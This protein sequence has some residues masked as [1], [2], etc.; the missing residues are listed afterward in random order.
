MICRRCRTA[1]PDLSVYCSGCGR[2]LTQ[3]RGSA[4]PG[5]RPLLFGALGAAVL[6]GLYFLY[7]VVAPGIKPGPTRSTETAGGPAGQPAQT[8]Y[9]S[10][11]LVLGYAAVRGA[12]GREVARITAAVFEDGWVALPTAALLGGEE[13]TFQAGRVGAVPISTGRWEPGEPVALWQVKAG[14]APANPRLAAWNQSLPLEWQPLPPAG[15][16]LRFEVG[17]NRRTGAFIG[18]ARPPEVKAPGVFVQEGAVVGWTFGEPF[19]QAYLW[20]GPAG[21]E[22]TPSIRADQ[23]FSSVSSNSRE[24][25]FLRQLDAGTGETSLVRL[26]ALARGFRLPSLLA[27]EDI[28]PSL[29]SSAVVARMD[30]LIAELIQNG[31][32][33]EVVRVL[34]DQ[35]LREAADP[36]LV[37]GAVLALAKDQD[38]N[39]AIRRLE[40][41]EKD[42]FAARGPAPPEL[43]QFKSRLYKDWL[44]KIVEKGDYYNGLT[45]YEEAQRA[46][47]EDLEIRL[48]GVEAAIAEKSLDRARELLEARDYPPALKE[49]AARLGTQVDSRREDA[50]AVTIRFNPGVEHIPVDAVI[51]GFHLHKFI[52]DTGASMVTIPASAL[53]VLRI[54]VDDST[55][56]KAV[57]TAGG[58]VFA[59]EIT[60]DSISLEKCTVYNVKALVLDIPG[61]EDYGLLGLSFLNGFSV[62][63]DKQRGILRLKKRQGR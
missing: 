39:R 19:D 16:S 20:A 10:T 30:P 29:R 42:V 54:K 32:A 43:E 40:K 61:F 38:Y 59:Q 53:D 8:V 41:I 12:A 51:N 23:F 57:S 34:D 46:F 35:T 21:A 2:P 55:P 31:Q 37:K 48:L 47:P 1:N 28:P 14:S 7:R 60:L 56:V 52:I 15:A 22:L 9:A 18:F 62:E 50:D 44:R 17:P 58:L 49:W 4:G 33:G 5:L 13:I 45:A 27:P 63:I 24:A 11:P 3:R 26:E 36:A 6:F 25:Y